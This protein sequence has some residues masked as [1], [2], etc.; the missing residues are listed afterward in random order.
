MCVCEQKKIPPQTLVSCWMASGPE[1]KHQHA[2]KI[3]AS[4]SLKSKAVMN[5]CCK[6]TGGVDDELE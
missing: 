6:E 3:E 5:C 4:S 2:A 1:I